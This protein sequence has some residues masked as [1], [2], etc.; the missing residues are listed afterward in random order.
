ML[1]DKHTGLSKNTISKHLNDDQHVTICGKCNNK[2]IDNY[3]DSE[4]RWGLN[5]PEDQIDHNKV[6]EIINKE[7]KIKEPKPEPEIEYVKETKDTQVCKICEEPTRR[8]TDYGLCKKCD[9]WLLHLAQSKS[10]RKDLT[11][12][13]NKILKGE[14]LD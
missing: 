14:N 1:W 5:K 8:I 10:G 13:H 2:V 7:L 6:R 12:A 9:D 11:E 4:K 3:S